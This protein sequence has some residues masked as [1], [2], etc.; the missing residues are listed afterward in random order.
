[1]SST[2]KDADALAEH[3]GSRLSRYRNEG[4]FNTGD[5]ISDMQ[6]QQIYTNY[7]R[8]GIDIA[9]SLYCPIV[10]EYTKPNEYRMF[11]SS[12][13]SNFA[14][15]VGIEFDMIEEG[16]NTEVDVYFEYRY[17]MISRM[18]DDGADDGRIR[19]ITLQGGENIGIQ[20]GAVPSTLTNDWTNFS[21]TFVFNAKR[22]PCAVI[23]NRSSVQGYMDIRN[24]YAV[25]R[26]SDVD[27]VIVRVNTFN[28]NRIFNPYR[29]NEGD[30]RPLSI[31]RAQKVNRLRL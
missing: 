20:Y 21:G 27:N 17:P 30:I 6:T 18:Q 11:N 29:E 31:V 22:G 14:H 12:S 7:G 19:M 13:D 5:T 26:T 2:V 4:H 23:L 10:R 9:I 1:M 16:I 15:L 3:T 24:A 28:L 25:V 8:Y